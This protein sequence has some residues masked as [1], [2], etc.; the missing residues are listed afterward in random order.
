[1]TKGFILVYLSFFLVLFSMSDILPYGECDDY[2]LAAVSMMNDGTFGVSNEDVLLYHEAIPEWKDYPLA[3]SGRFTRSGEELTF[4]FPTYSIACLPLLCLFRILKLPVVYAFPLTNLLAYAGM[5]WLVHRR[6]NISHGRRLMLILLLA[7]G[8]IRFYY[9]WVSAEVLIAALLG[10]AMVFWHNRQWNRAALFLSVA[11]TM[12]PTALAAGLFMIAEFLREEYAGLKAKS[13]GKEYFPPALLRTVKFGCCFLVGLLPFAYNYYHTG[14]I[15][16]TASYDNFLIDGSLVWAHMRAYLFDLNFGILPYYPLLLPLAFLMAV[17]SLIR[18]KPR[19]AVMFAAFL[20]T[21]FA[22]S[23]MSHINSG[24]TGIA[25][26]SA[27]SVLILLFAITVFWDDCFAGKASAGAVNTCICLLLGT[28]LLWESYMVYICKPLLYTEMMP[29]A[30]YALDTHPALYNPLPSTFYSRIAHTD[31]GYDYETPVLYRDE[32]DFIRK[33]L[34]S[35]KDADKLQRSVFGSS[36]DMRWF[37]AQLQK[38]DE[39]ERYISVP[40]SKSLLLCSL[41]DPSQ[42]ITF[43]QDGYNAGDYAQ[44]GF[45]HPEKTHSWTEKPEA[46]IVFR[47]DKDFWDKTLTARLTL[48]D[49]FGGAQKV[50]IAVNG[51]CVMDT[52]VGNDQDI[53]FTFTVPDSGLVDITF[54]L[55]HAVSPSFLG[56][57]ED[58]RQLALAVES[59][60]IKEANAKP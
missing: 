24:M 25:R 44:E 54:S 57:S 6:L 27:W 17:I 38:L 40:R 36:E 7:F 12:N 20:A 59:L 42:P 53:V 5:L 60:M 34:A 2:A 45:S 3:L 49:V 37:A 16:L 1:M 43:T 14:Y 46:K 47:L 56:L 55:P 39:K 13:F 22:Y 18:R 26:Y 8:T 29:P 30:S 41:Y 21:V 51:H 32:R 58:S 52:M 50:S 9:T 15:N 28:S 31:G 10:C 35:R 33:I 48:L 11:G 23:F 4:Y 19:F